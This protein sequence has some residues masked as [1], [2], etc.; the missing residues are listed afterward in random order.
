MRFQHQGQRI[1]LTS[2]LC[3]ESCSAPRT[4]TFFYARLCAATASAPRTAPLR[5]HINPLRLPPS[6]AAEHLFGPNPY[7]DSLCPEVKYCFTIPPASTW[8]LIDCGQHPNMS[9]AWLPSISGRLKWTDMKVLF[10]MMPSSWLYL[11]NEDI[12]RTELHLTP[13]SAELTSWFLSVWNTFLIFVL[14]LNICEF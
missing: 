7:T 10:K 3:T 8:A 13:H 6:P 1:C 5:F 2:S 9:P 12:I 11:S 4:E 14:F